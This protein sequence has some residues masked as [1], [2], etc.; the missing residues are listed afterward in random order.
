MFGNLRSPGMPGPVA[1][2]G[3]NALPHPDREIPS[4]TFSTQS[5]TWPVGGLRYR[6]SQ[7]L[8]AR[9]LRSFHVCLSGPFTPD[10]IGEQPCGAFRKQAGAGKGFLAVSCF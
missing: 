1:Y 4:L 2:T 5:S 8:L 9:G 6:E 3:R 10:G 7:L